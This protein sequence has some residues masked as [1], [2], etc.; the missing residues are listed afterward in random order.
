MRAKAS[1]L[2]HDDFLSGCLLRIT[3]GACATG[4]QPVR[5][6]EFFAEPAKNFQAVPQRQ[7]ACSGSGT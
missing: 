1:P 7:P 4:A 2:E 5:C 6:Q 3:F